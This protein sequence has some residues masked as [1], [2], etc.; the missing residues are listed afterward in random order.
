MTQNRQLG[1]CSA[2]REPNGNSE[3][4]P[5]EFAMTTLSAPLPIR[6][7]HPELE[8]DYQRCPSLGFDPKAEVGWVRCLAHSYPTPL[9]RWHY[10]E[11]YELHIIT[12]TSGRAFVGDWIGSFEPGHVVLCG[13]RLPHNWISH[14]LPDNGVCNHLVIQFLH[15]PLEKSCCVIPELADAGPLLERARYGIEF[16]GFSTHAV[17]HWKKVKAANGLFRLAAFLEFMAVIAQWKEYRLLSSVQMRG[18]NN[19]SELEQINY[20]VDRIN[21]NP[22][23]PT[24]ATELAATLGMSESRFSRFF[25]RATGNTYTNFVNQVRINRACQLLMNSDR[26]ISSIGYEVGFNNLANFNRRFLEIKGI[27]P[28]AFRKLA[29]SRFADRAQLFQRTASHHSLTHRSN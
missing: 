13:P 5:S 19:S 2:E 12:D 14:D 11:E 23:K 8:A 7:R 26:Y 25:H 6:S 22:E 20:I 4:N 1:S 16:F 27:T 9:T 18:E 29:E 24:P 28:S 15:T 17:E 10:H 21:N 3:L